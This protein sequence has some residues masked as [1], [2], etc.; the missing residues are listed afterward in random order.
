MIGGQTVFTNTAEESF[1][2]ALNETEAVEMKETSE[3]AGDSVLVETN[4]RQVD[5]KP[6]FA[7]L[8]KAMRRRSVSIF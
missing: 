5:L 7:R 1:I 4:T 2:S 3:T 8:K 6:K